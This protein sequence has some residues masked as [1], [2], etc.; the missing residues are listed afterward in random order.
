[1][2]IRE[3]LEIEVDRV[4]YWT[5]STIVLKCLNDDSQWFQT[6]ESNCLTVDHL[7]QTGDM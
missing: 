5:D 2:E 4:N 1:M 3:E 6:F 7:F